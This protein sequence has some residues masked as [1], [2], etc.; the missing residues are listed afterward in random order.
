VTINDPNATAQA[1]VPSSSSM[2]TPATVA[3][4]DCDILLVENPCPN[5]AI[6]CTKVY[7]WPGLHLQKQYGRRTLL[8]FVY[9]IRCCERCFKVLTARHVVTDKLW[10]ALAPVAAR[11]N[12]GV[13]P[14]R[15]LTTIALAPFT[16]PSA[17]AVMAARDRDLQRQEAGNG[18]RAKE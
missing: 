13:V 16:D 1:P 6:G 17:L 12:W 7:L 15:P 14:Q 5:P 10:E 8:E 3:Q 18:D 9:D 4:I 2:K 11:N